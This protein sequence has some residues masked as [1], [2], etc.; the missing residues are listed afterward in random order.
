MAQ[1]WLAWGVQPAALL[2][3]GVAEY[4]AAAV[5]GV[6]SLEEALSLAIGQ[7]RVWTPQP[8]KMP[9]WS[10]ATGAWLTAQE[11]TD[12]EYWARARRN[13]VTVRSESVLQSL[14][15]EHVILQL[16]S[17]AKANGVETE[18]QPVLQTLG[19]LWLRDV[20]IDWAGFYR[21][22]TRKRVL[23]PTYPFERRRYWIDV[24][25]Q[26]K[27]K[28]APAVTRAP[29]IADW[30]YRAEWRPA[31]LDR[32]QSTAAASDWLV[33]GG[34]A[35]GEAVA[36]RLSGRCCED[37]DTTAIA[38]AQAVLHLGALAQR[39]A[40][41]HGV[42]R[43]HDLQEHG[44]YS[45]LRVA[46]TL[47]QGQLVVV[48]PGMR[49][50]R[51]G[52]TPQAE[53]ATLV[54][55][56]K[57]AAQ[58]NVALRV[59]SVDVD[60]VDL[61]AQAERMALEC[62]FGTE[63]VVA[64]RGQERSTESYAPAHLDRTTAIRERGVY[65]ITGGFGPVGL[66]LAAHLAERYR[67]RLV[68]VSR[69]GGEGRNA[70]I[71]HL[72]S[73]GADVMAVAADA[74]D[75]DAMR[76]AIARVHERFGPINGVIHAAGVSEQVPLPQLTAAHVAPQF[77]AKAEGLYVLEDVLAGETSLD[78]CVVFSSLSAVLGGLGFGA[79]AAANGFMD[80]FVARH[81]ARG[82]G[83]PWTSIAWD[84]WRSPSAEPSRLG[85]TVSAYE[86]APAEAVDAFERAVG[87]VG[88]LVN[89]TGDL[90]AR[91]RQWVLLESLMTP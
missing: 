26:A 89:S 28:A 77:R 39:H 12:R 29:D 7:P 9:I 10:A 31:P 81:N 88:V 61:E 87:A 1:V 13:R 78:F 2:G 68:L 40:S 70:D 30:F 24:E 55:L 74:S 75:L 64:W 66:T 41:S 69:R 5:A 36:Q 71:A 51:E 62:R 63:P 52:E 14:P 85:G 53:Y 18:L 82:T 35:L 19:E 49:A 38:Q 90:D 50:V 57:V 59:R 56:L 79:Y 58:E 22:E 16:G 44:Y 25:P 6:M 91:I 20:A 23:L 17:L 47:E 34:G 33:V 3:V 60:D 48:S 42:A 43:F 21:D 32:D 83:R 37:N 80:A 4:A 65:L 76:A 72:E 15:Q 46:Q 73:L 84:T 54:G 67:A 86:M 11:A 8:P 27:A 45:V